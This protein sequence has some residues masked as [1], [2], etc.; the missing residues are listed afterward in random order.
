MTWT[1]LPHTA[2][3]KAALDAPDLPGLYAAAVDLVR[4]LLVG[5]SPVEARSAVVVVVDG[6]PGCGGEGVGEAGSEGVG[7]V[8]NEGAGR[9]GGEGV[10]RSEGFGEDERFFRFVRELVYL[11]DADGF[12]PAVLTCVAPL[13][14]SGET[15]DDRRHVVEHGIKAVTRHQYRFDVGPHGYH[16]EVVFDL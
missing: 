2:D 8:G 6:G 5:D 9:A 15:F 12:V 7:E 4:V 1:L 13:S 10:G 3:V 11:S 14:V 16:A